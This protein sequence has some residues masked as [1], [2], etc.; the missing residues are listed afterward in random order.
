MGKKNHKK[1]ILQK[2]LLKFSQCQDPDGMM[3]EWEDI[4]MHYAW[5]L[6]PEG[7]AD[8]DGKTLTDVQFV[9]SKKHYGGLCSGIDCPCSHVNI[10]HLC[11]I[12]N[13]YTLKTVIVGCVCVNRFLDIHLPKGFWRILEKMYLR[14]PVIP[15]EDI[16]AA[17]P[18]FKMNGY[19]QKFMEDMRNKQVKPSK[20]TE[21]QRNFLVKVNSNILYDINYWHLR[22]TDPTFFNLRWEHRSDKVHRL[23]DEIFI[24]L[25]KRKEE[26]ESKK[27]R[28]T[29]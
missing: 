13:K 14:E 2:Y 12:R 25:T 24:E 10:H 5:S 9:R 22:Q 4:C 11:Y 29:P 27:R 21:R 19:E 20:L 28:L 26:R 16:L 17:F 1:E 15:S 7:P 8:N 23:L 3:E 6:P 18:P